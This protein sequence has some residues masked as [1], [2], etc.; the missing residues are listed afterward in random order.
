M[1]KNKKKFDAVAFQR[2]VRE[3]LSEKY[4]NNPDLFEKDLERIREKYGMKKSKKYK[5]QQ[6]NASLAAEPESKYGK[7]K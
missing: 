3:E 7:K 4:Y 1:K 2:K 5:S 6:S